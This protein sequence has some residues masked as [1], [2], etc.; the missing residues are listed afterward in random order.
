[1]LRRV[2]VGSG[3]GVAARLASS[4]SFLG[5]LVVLGACHQVFEWF[6]LPAGLT[7]VSRIFIDLNELLPILNDLP[8]DGGSFELANHQALVAWCLAL[9]L[10]PKLITFELVDLVG[11]TFRDLLGPKLETDC[12]PV[13]VGVHEIEND[14]GDAGEALALRAESVVDLEQV[15]LR[16]LVASRVCSRNSTLVDLTALGHQLPRRCVLGVGEVQA[17]YDVDFTYTCRSDTRSWH[18]FRVNLWSDLLGEVHAQF[19]GGRNSIY[20]T[21]YA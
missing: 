4:V 15:S 6:I 14:R 13:V 12:A 21:D 8:F 7:V 3:A 11:A 17:L 2:A 20:A 10:R 16:G 5:V 18:R 1:M 19:Y 9:E